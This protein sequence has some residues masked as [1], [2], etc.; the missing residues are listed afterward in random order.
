MALTITRAVLDAQPG[1]VLS[2]GRNWT[3]G[4]VRLLDWQGRPVV[5]KDYRGAHPLVRGVLGRWMVRHEEAIF[6]DLRGVAG[7]PDTLG[8]VDRFA[9]AR[10]F[11]D[12]RPLQTLGR[13]EVR[14]ETFASLEA[15]VRNLHARGIAHADL[16]HRDIIIDAAGAPSVIDFSSAVRRGAGWN[17]LRRWL[18]R[19]SCRMDLRSVFKLK[20]RFLEAPLSPGEARYLERAPILHRLGKSIRRH[21]RRADRR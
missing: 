12:G 17:P 5:I 15:I 8:R 11:I 19:Q 21:F 1:K 18:F 14:V 13:G 2:P 3:K 10:E 7:V 20:S 16:H 6:R 9:F 4:Q